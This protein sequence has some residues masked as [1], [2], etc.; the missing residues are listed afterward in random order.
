MLLIFQGSKPKTAVILFLYNNPWKPTVISFII[1]HES[2]QTFFFW[3]GGY[4]ILLG[5]PVTSPHFR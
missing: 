4:F 2:K 1:I 5:T 3:G